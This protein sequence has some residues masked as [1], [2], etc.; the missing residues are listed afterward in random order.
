M[1][2]WVQLKRRLRS[3]KSNDWTERLEAIKALANLGNSRALVPLT[4]ALNDPVLDVQMAAVE[5]LV[6]FRDPHATEALRTLLGDDQGKIRQAVVRALA[7]LGEGKWEQWIKGDDQDFLRLGQSADRDAVDILI[8]ALEAKKVTLRKAAIQSLGKLRSSKAVEPLIKILGDSDEQVRRSAAESLKELGEPG[9]LGR[10]QGDQGD[11]SRLGRSK[12]PRA[13]EALLYG[14][15]DSAVRKT[16]AYAFAQA[17]LSAVDP[18]I[19]ALIENERICDENIQQAFKVGKKTEM[20]EVRMFGIGKIGHLPADGTLGDALFRHAEREKQEVQ[21]AVVTAFVSI[22]PPA[23]EPLIEALS[24][25]ECVALVAANAL[26]RLGDPRALEPLIKAMN[27]TLSS[28]GKAATKALGGLRNGS[29]FNALINAL[30]HKKWWVR[31]AA[32]ETLGELGDKR[33]LDVLI[34]ALNNVNED[35]NDVFVAAAE[36]LG[37]LG[38]ERAI[39]PLTEALGFW[40]RLADKSK[41]RVPEDHS[42]ELVMLHE[43]HLRV[44]QA[45]RNALKKCYIQ[46]C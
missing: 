15:R 37:K 19:R 25:R 6:H 36:A 8:R 26:G 38:D 2:K 20:S 32:A 27:H 3:L 34:K 44:C 29:G 22:G 1:F 18:L 41:P 46:V 42:F 7:A 4:K 39:R 30:H 17:G 28:V 14:L 45:I 23:V 10:V 24:A 16:V 9:W 11:F 21:E 40:T 43:S 35:S 31:A 12:D 13:F 33:A 5:A